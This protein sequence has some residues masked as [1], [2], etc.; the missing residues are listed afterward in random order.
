MVGIG[1]IF[2]LTGG[3]GSGS[4]GSSSGITTINSQD[5]PAVTL[6]GVSGVVVQVTAPDVIS[7][8]LSGSIT[9][10]YSESFTSITSG[11]FNHSLGTMDVIVQ[12]RDNASGGGHIFLPDE[13]I[14]ENF[15]FVSVT[16]NQPQ[17]GRVVI[18]G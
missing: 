11:L 3:G 12:C 8:G 18:I 16:F 5:G 6:L 2:S 9:R 1:G 7:I 14:I 17:S 10:K 15:N 13:I 4:S